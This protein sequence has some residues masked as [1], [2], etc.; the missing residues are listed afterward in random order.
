MRTT[1]KLLFASM[2]ILAAI[3]LSTTAQAAEPKSRYML[4][5]APDSSARSTSE[6]DSGQKVQWRRWEGSTIGWQILAGVAGG[7][8]GLFAGGFVGAAIDNA[9]GG[10]DPEWGCLSGGI[11]GAFLGPILGSWLGV[12]LAGDLSGGDGHFAGSLVGTILGGAAGATAGMLIL[13]VEESDTDLAFL[14]I[15]AAAALTV[16][17]G[18]V[19][20]HLTA[21]T[22]ITGVGVA[23]TDGG[24]TLGITGRF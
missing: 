6:L 22:E 7:T 13:G 14:A 18:I 16:G 1:M 24:A 23:P 11:Y 5:S 10:C 19:G 2:L 4:A 8:V 17:G 15:P 21:S 20:Y 3:G 9:V 12:E